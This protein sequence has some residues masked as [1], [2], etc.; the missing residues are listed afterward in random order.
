MLIEA[1][2]FLEITTVRATAPIRKGAPA[3]VMRETKFGVRVRV[4]V[5]DMVSAGETGRGDSEG[6]A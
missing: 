5:E 1:A 3:D 6:R 4:R 2:H